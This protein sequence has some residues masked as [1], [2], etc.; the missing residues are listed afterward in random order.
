MAAEDI[1]GTISNLV[2][3]MSSLKLN[4]IKSIGPGGSVVCRENSYYESFTADLSS[5]PNQGKS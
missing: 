4:S 1:V 3:I 2:Y 5:I